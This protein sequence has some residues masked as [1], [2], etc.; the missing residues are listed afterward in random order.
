MLAIS[1]MLSPEL[2][3]LPDSDKLGARNCAPRVLRHRLTRWIIARV[4]DQLDYPDGETWPSATAGQ[5]ATAAKR[6]ASTHFL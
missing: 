4:K 2:N 6:F 5:A 1:T 3:E